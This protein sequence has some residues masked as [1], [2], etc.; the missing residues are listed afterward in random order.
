MGAIVTQDSALAQGLQQGLSG[1]ASGLQQR[2]AFQAKEMQRLKQQQEEIANR[3]KYGTV[4]NNIMENL[5]ENPTT[6]DI[7]KGLSTASAEGV[8]NEII[9]GMGT[10]YKT[11]QQSK[12]GQIL[13]VNTRDDFKDLLNR[14]GME[15]EQAELDTPSRSRSARVTLDMATSMSFA[16]HCQ[17]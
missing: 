10:L 7:I 4:L 15:D 6:M 14:F 16:L 11:L 1:I 2:G 12:Q 5:P 17:R 13:D 8:P 9:K 3:K